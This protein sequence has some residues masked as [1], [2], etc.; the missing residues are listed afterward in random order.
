MVEGQVPVLKICPV[1]SVDDETGCDRIKVRMAPEDRFTNGEESYVFPLLPKML[2]IKPKVGEA[3]LVINAVGNDANTQ[4]YYIGPVITQQNHM[5]FEGY[6]YEAM[7]TFNNAAFGPD[8]NPNSDPETDGAFPDETDISITGRRNADVQIK[9]NDVRIRCGVRKG[10]MR[11][12]K[13]NTLD[14]AYMLLRYHGGD[15]HLNLG[16][17]MRCNSSAT[18]V[19]DKINLIGNDS[20]DAFRVRDRKDLITDEEMKNII[21]KAHKLPYGDVLIEFLGYFR[22][23]FMSHTHPYPMMPPVAD[24]NCTKIAQYNLQEMLSDTV[25]IS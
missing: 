9:E 23:A 13:F 5:E 14:P 21:E 4:R 2:H 6:K 18:I 10:D 19:A 20:K 24:A 16:G 8:E 22:T 25:R 17:T 15:S 11:N 7:A 1:I 3:V 12:F